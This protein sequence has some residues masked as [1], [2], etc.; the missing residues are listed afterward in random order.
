M[1]LIEYKQKD[2]L[3]LKEGL[4]CAWQRLARVRGDGSC[5][6]SYYKKDQ[7]NRPHGHPWTFNFQLAIDIKQLPLFRLFVGGGGVFGKHTKM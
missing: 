2:L 1:I 5:G 3:F 6:H 7:K 4:L